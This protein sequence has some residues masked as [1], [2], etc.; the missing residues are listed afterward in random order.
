MDLSKLKPA[1]GSVS[2]KKRIGRGEGSGYG[3]F[4]TRGTKG[5]QSRSGYKRRHNY[6]GGQMPIQRRIPKFGFK[7]FNRKH[8]IPV[9]LGTIQYLVDKKGGDKFDLES[10]KKHGVVSKNKDSVKILGK[11][12]LKSKVE[13]KANAF[14]KSAQKAIEKQGGKAIKQ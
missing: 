14:S 8:F 10:F 1:K 7:N 5:A 11:G 4:S 3:G 2:R 12:E 13:V 9:N 6:E